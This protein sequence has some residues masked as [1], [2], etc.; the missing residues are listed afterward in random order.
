VTAQGERG[1]IEPGWPAFGPF[2]EL[3]QVQFGELDAGDRTDQLGRLRGI[4]SQLVR[5]DFRHRAGR[6]HSGQR[7]RGI[8]AGDN[9]QLRR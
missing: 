1:Q 7:Q 5:P 9:D 3:G 6:A 2:D 4:E 8:G